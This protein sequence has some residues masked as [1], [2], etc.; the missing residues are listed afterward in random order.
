MTESKSMVAWGQGQELGISCRGKRELLEL[1]K[2]LYLDLDCSVGYIT[3][4]N[5]P[6]SSLYLSK[7]EGKVY[8]S[9]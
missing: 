2:V 6:N 5:F 3:E 7:A 4:H 1:R 9:V 8:F